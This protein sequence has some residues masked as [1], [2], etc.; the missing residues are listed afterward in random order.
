M[1]NF[2]TSVLAMGMIGFLGCAT[3]PSQPPKVWVSTNRIINQDIFNQDKYQCEQEAGTFSG[4]YS[5]AGT[6]SVNITRSGTYLSRLNQCMQA[7]GYVLEDKVSYDAKTMEVKR[8]KDNATAKIGM[9]TPI[10]EVG[11]AIILA[12]DSASPAGKAGFEKGD[13]IKKVNGIGALSPAQIYFY[14]MSSMKPGEP[15]VFEIERNM[16]PKTITVIPEKK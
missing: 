2:F 8:L 4:A 11:Q 9:V 3:I 1:K 5:Q 7:K 14:I 6:T 15:M 10:S 12:V 13:V 16:F